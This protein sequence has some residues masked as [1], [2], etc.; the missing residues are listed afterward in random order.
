MLDF[1]NQD[2]QNLNRFPQHATYK[3]KA[4]IDQIEKEKQVS[5]ERKNLEGRCKSEKQPYKISM[6]TMEENLKKMNLDD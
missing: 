3:A 6:W 2:D 5:M 4:E 1:K